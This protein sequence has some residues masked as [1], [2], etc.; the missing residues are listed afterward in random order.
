[1]YVCQVCGRWFNEPKE[2]RVYMGEF[3]GL[4]AEDD[5]LGCPYCGGSYDD[6]ATN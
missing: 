2:Y 5:V 6:D 4:P 3:W 1:M